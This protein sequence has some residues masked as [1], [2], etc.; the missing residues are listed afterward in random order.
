MAQATIYIKD[1][2]NRILN[3]TKAQHG[4]NDKSAVIDYVVE[5]YA[6]MVFPPELMPKGD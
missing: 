5:K 1:K 3:I 2:T 6:E 4:L